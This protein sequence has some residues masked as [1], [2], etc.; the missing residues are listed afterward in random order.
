MIRI[1]SCNAG[2]T[3]L[4]LLG[5]GVAAA[6]ARNGRHL[7]SWVVSCAGEEVGKVGEAETL[8]AGFS[9]LIHSRRFTLAELHQLSFK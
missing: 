4:V 8:G 5:K 9:L 1:P 7:G 6:P 3:T 2:L